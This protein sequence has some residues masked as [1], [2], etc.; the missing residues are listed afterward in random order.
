[1][2][3]L[4]L[5]STIN[6]HQSTIGSRRAF[7]LIELLVVITIIIG[8]VAMLLP[9]ID[10]ALANARCVVC[11]NNQKQIGVTVMNYASDNF[12]VIPQ[13][14]A[15]T[16]PWPNHFYSFYNVGYT[17]TWLVNAWRGYVPG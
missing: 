5:K 1:M 14:S 9:S 10:R 15:N 16:M 12:F 11:A 7:T 4:N 8:L 13:R 3:A 2:T 17:D 6:H